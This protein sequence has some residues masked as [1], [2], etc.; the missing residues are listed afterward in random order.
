[1]RES[2]ED[3]DLEAGDYVVLNRGD[4]HVPVGSPDNVTALIYLELAAY[5]DVDPFAETIVYACESF[6]LARYRRQDAPLRGLLLD[7]IDDDG[8]GGRRDQR[9]AEL[10]RLLCEGYS[11]DRYYN[12][13][14]DVTAAHREKFLTIHAYLRANLGRRDALDAVAH[15][16]HYSK[17]YVSHL[18]K[19]V[20]AMSFSDM[21]TALRLMPAEL[22]LLTTDDTVLEISTAGGF[23]D[24]KYFT[25]GFADWFKQSLTEYRVQYRRE[26]FHDKEIKPVDAGVPSDLVRAA[27]LDNG[28]LLG[29]LASFA[30]INATPCLVLEYTTKAATAE[31]VAAVA[32]RLRTANV[33]DIAIWLVYRGLHHHAGVDHVIA[34]AADRHALDIQAILIT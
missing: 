22:L 6:D 27:D 10:I 11:L 5:R 2:S 18:V 17:S 34:G 16:Y 8:D 24:V 30:Q 13:D 20:A 7:I 28:Y 33:A 19:D 4:P 26:M 31:L 32:E 21:L 15:E 12:R 23:S 1:V 25:R 14:Q 29:G 3:F 9:S